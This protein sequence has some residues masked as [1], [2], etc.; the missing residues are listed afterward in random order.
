M[1]TMLSPSHQALVADLL[2]Y[3]RE[4]R[5]GGAPL[6]RDPVVQDLLVQAFIDAEI[7][8]LLEERDWRLYDTGRELTFQAAQSA[9]WRAQASVR[10][11]AIVRDVLGPYAL[12][13]E[14]DPRAPCQGDFA[15]HQRESLASGDGV[16]ERKEAIARAIGLNGGTSLRQAQDIALQKRFPQ[17]PSRNPS[18]GG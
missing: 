1:D 9:V 8:R 3:A 7:A 6:S 4:T 17:T 5:R 14:E 2:Q 12:L 13:D 11:A 18:A 15:R 16:N 10:L